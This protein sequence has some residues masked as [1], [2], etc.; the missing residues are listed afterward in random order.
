MLPDVEKKPAAKNAGGGIAGA[1]VSTAIA[2][3]DPR[4]QIEIPKRRR[5]RTASLTNLMGK[6]KQKDAK[7]S[8]KKDKAPRGKTTEQAERSLKKDRWEKR[9][10]SQYNWKGGK[11]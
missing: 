11:K 3:E 1:T 7:S 8:R 10:P 5:R 4:E 9:D 2:K 6:G